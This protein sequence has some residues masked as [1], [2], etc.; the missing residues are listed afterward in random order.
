MDALLEAVDALKAIPEVRT[1]EALPATSSINEPKPSQPQFAERRP[2]AKHPRKPLLQHRVV[3]SQPKP[4]PPINNNINIPLPSF[5]QHLNEQSLSPIPHTIPLRPLSISPARYI[6]FSQPPD[7][8]LF[9]FA[10]LIHQKIF[11]RY[12]L[13][14]Y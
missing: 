3:T 4:P 8:F 9:F 2:T 6:S 7:L 10:V 14:I 12:Q 5:E 13:M 11:H 1:I